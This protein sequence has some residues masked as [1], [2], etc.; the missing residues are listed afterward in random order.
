MKHLLLVLLFISV[1]LY[2]QEI[3]LCNYETDGS[4]VYL[5][6]Y[7]KIIVRKS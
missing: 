4:K 6:G 1:K 2:S 3:N 7:T 5:G